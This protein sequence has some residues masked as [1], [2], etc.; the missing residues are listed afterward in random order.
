VTPENNV[1]VKSRFEKKEFNRI[2][3]KNFITLVNKKKSV[4]A[5]TKKFFCASGAVFTTLHNV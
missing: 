4:V 3:V 1:D 2:H 5:V